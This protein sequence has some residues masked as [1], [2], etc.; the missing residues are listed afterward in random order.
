MRVY[1]KD[2]FINPIE[3]HALILSL[4]IK[5]ACWEAGSMRD[6]NPGRLLKKT[7]VSG[8][9]R[10]GQ[11]R[12]RIFAH[13]TNQ[14]LPSR[15]SQ[16]CRGAWP[17]K[18]AGPPCPAPFRTIRRGT[19]LLTRKVLRQANTYAMIP[20]RAVAAG[21]ATAVTPPRSRRALRG[22]SHAGR[23][24]PSASAGRETRVSR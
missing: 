24:R 10:S 21:I 15:G 8:F 6:V 23:K 7:G 14:R 3:G 13:R 19:R 17:I 16:F 11:P 5:G 20:R 12:W 1:C 18:R 2:S 22:S 9:L 4:E